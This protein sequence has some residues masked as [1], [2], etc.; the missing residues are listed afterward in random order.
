MARE[1]PSL[2]RSP[3]FPFASAPCVTI[4]GSGS[5][6]RF[7]LRLFVAADKKEKKHRILQRKKERKRETSKQNKETKTTIVDIVLRDNLTRRH[8]PSRFTFSISRE[9]LIFPPLALT[10][11]LLSIN[12]QISSPL[13]TPLFLFLNRSFTAS[14]ILSPQTHVQIPSPL[15]LSIHPGRRCGS[16]GLRPSRQQPAAS[17]INFRA[18]TPS[19]ISLPFV[20][21]PVPLF[22]RGP[23]LHADKRAAYYG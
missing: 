12:Y 8:T 5:T 15:F 6:T 23:P 17:A 7:R 14:S 4:Q 19:N 16:R 11:P 10:L 18:P 1:G 2:I 3:R 21:A 13:S 9:N 22:A 20:Y